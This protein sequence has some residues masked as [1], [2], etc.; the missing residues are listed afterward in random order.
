MAILLLNVTYS[1]L[2]WNF[3]WSDEK[4]DHYLYRREKRFC[5]NNDSRRKM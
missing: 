3:L 5:N 1:D 4:M 2:Y